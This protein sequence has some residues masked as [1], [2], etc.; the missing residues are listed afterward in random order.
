MDME[1][2]GESSRDACWQEVSIQVDI[3]E[4]I[5]ETYYGDITRVKSSMIM[6]QEMTSLFGYFVLLVI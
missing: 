4:I 3:D 5:E 1:E 2:I 6:T